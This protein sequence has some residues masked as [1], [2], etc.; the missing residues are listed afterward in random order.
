VADLVAIATGRGGAVRIDLLEQAAGSLLGGW[1]HS[2]VSYRSG[3]DAALLLV[4]AG[5]DPERVKAIAEQTRSTL[6]GFGIR[7]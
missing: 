5:A 4:E 7:R 2:A 1:Q 3:R 6:Q